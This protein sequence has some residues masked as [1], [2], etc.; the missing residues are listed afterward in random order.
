MK[1]QNV[2]FENAAGQ[3]LRG[4]LE[5][6]LSGPVRHYAL[7]AHCFTCS[8]DFKAAANLAKALSQAGIGVLRFDFTGLGQSEGDF[9]DTNFSSNREDL[10]AAAQF[11]EREYRAPSLLIGH[12]LGG[13]AVLMTA[14]ELPSVEAVVTIGAPSQL[15]HVQKLFQSDLA[16]IKTKGV[17]K[18]DIG[19]RPFNI[20]QQFIEDLERYQLK[21]SLGKWRERALLILHSPQD[22]TVSIDHAA[23]LYAAAHH[24]KSFVSLDGADHLLSA[25]QDSQY[26]GSLIAAWAQRYLSL[27][28]K[29]VP[30]AAPKE[31]QAE[32]EAQGLSTRL[33]MGHH[34][35]WADE[36]KAQ[37]GEDLGP[38]P[39]QYL[40]A[41]L[42][43]CTAMTLRLYAD[44]K[45]WPLQRVRVHLEYQADYRDDQ[46]HCSRED[47]R[48]GRFQRWLEL[49]GELDAQQ[50]KRLLEIADKC[51]VHRSL[52]KGLTVETHIWEAE[53]K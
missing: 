27:G 1:K 23:A 52:S 12:S 19:G 17:A 18:V 2:H 36:P 4:R 13:A 41:G 39:Y 49:E 14:E 37:G 32:I 34:H 6:P 40:G 7:F 5:E 46:E 9:A 20:K 25:A 26:A 35:L 45:K 48:L 42:G 3:R 16:E 28:E 29:P 33:Q 44:R 43:A 21:E 47:R 8:K 30:E 53:E 11:L 51:P 24:P 38:S 31:V 50:K 10:L 22:R 15:S